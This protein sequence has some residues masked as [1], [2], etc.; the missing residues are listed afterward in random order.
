MLSPNGTTSSLGLWIRMQLGLVSRRTV[1]PGE[2]YTLE[3]IA[4]G[5]RI[6]VRVN[7]TQ[8][9]D[10][11]DPAGTFRKGHITLHSGDLLGPSVQYRKVEVKEYK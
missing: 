5:N 2:W 4:L 11:D 3:V 8:V 6:V 10:Y 7:G 1:E 9:V